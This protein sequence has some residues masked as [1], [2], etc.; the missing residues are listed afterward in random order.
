MW[1]KKKMSLIDFVESVKSF[2]YFD[3]PNNSSAVEVGDYTW[4]LYDQVSSFRL[5]L[6]CLR[7]SMQQH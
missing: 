3:F 2:A 4:I 6:L 1:I 7:F 5:Q